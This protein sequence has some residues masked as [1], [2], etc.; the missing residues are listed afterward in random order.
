MR[1]IVLILLFVGFL[2]IVDGIYEEKLAAYKKNT[3]IEYRF[4]PRTQIEDAMYSNDIELKLMDMF[5]K[6]SPYFGRDTVDD[7]PRPA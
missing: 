7:I 5:Q 4:I 2:L 3:R 6:D 1:T